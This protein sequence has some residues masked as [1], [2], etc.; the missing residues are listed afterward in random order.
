MC[1][2]NNQLWKAFQNKAHK[3]EEIDEDGLLN[4]RQ[5]QTAEFG[6]DMMHPDRLRLISALNDSSK[7]KPTP[8][9]PNQLNQKLNQDRSNDKAAT[10]HEGGPTNAPS[11]PH[12]NGGGRRGSGLLAHYFTTPAGGHGGRDDRET[13]VEEDEAIRHAYTSKPRRRTLAGSSYDEDS[14]VEGP[15][16]AARAGGSPR[17]PLPGNDGEAA[18]PMANAPEAGERRDSHNSG[19]CVVLGGREDPERRPC[20]T[21]HQQTL[22]RTRE[23]DQQILEG[24]LP[25]EIFKWTERDH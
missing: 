18:G 1:E 16:D 14:E 22:G 3:G 17:R 21:G 12:G 11:T 24:V 4:L 9:G 25:N 20:G 5:K 7:K 10:H 8:G 13:H 23:E 2:A 19:H 15:N 6:G